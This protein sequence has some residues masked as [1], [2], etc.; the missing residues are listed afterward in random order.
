MKPQDRLYCRVMYALDVVN[1]ILFSADHKL[2][3][4]LWQTQST[5]DKSRTVREALLFA[6]RELQEE[7]DRLRAQGALYPE[8][9][10]DVKNKETD[11]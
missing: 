8:E 1:E 9:A 5:H 10:A 11:E 3:S 2:S 4:V 7:A 6:S